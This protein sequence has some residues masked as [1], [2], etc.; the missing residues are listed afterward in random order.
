[1]KKL[2]LFVLLSSLC[3][4]VFAQ[5][6]R[7]FEKP[8]NPSGYVGVYTDLEWCN[9]DQ[10]DF[11]VLEREISNSPTGALEPGVRKYLVDLII[12]QQTM[13]GISISEYGAMRIANTYV[14]PSVDKEFVKTLRKNY[15]DYSRNRS[16]DLKV[17]HAN[18]LSKEFL[19]KSLNF[20]K[21]DF[22]NTMK[23]GYAAKLG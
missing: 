17:K 2:L 3:S 4:I 5:K 15:F 6:S 1:M 10:F 16:Q 13:N 22:S 7:S 23:R 19:R 18:A 14:D 20:L 21:S 12:Y 9:Q 11:F 8:S